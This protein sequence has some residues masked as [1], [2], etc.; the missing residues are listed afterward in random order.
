MAIFNED[1]VNVDLQGGNLQRG[2]LNMQ[3]GEGDGS[4]NR[5]GVN[6]LNGGEPAS[7][8]G[9]SCVGYFIRPDGI[10]L[11]LN[12]TVSGNKA[13]VDLPAAAYAKEGNFSLAIKITGSGYE[14]TLRI[15]EGT[16][17]NTTTG[18]ISDPAGQLP[19]LE[20]YEEAVEDAEAA[21]EIIESM[22]VAATQI[23]GTRY[24][25]EITKDE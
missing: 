19:S 9:A 16:V 4:A 14:N 22:H 11:V 10:T 12:G 5:F 8:S 25:I 7:L 13:Y 3:V 15:V 6:V 2:Y 23:T 24:K 20:Q 1:I 18:E 21:A 17:I